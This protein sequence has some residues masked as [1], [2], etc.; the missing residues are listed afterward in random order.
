MYKKI[1]LLGICGIFL[2]LFQP[3]VTFAQSV[4]KDSLLFSNTD[5]TTSIQPQNNRMEGYYYRVFVVT[6]LIILI[7]LIGL[8]IY[9]KKSGHLTAVNKQAIKIIARRA[10]GPKQY[11][12]L[13]IIDGR[14][15]ALGV[16]DQSVNKIADLGEASNADMEA[17]EKQIENP[18]S[19]LQVLTKV[20]SKR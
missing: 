16:T 4:T 14:K 12:L 2:V 18:L 1:I 11:I 8:N 3:K 17:S 19:F 6:G 20:K 9:K 13:A 5:S 15:F 7:L 10:I